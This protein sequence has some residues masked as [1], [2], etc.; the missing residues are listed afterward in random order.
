MNKFKLLFLASVAACL[1]SA[2]DAQTS[3]T[4]SLVRF[5]LVYG[6]TFFGDIDVELFDD[7]PLTVSNFLANVGS[8]IYDN[9]ILHDLRPGYTLQGGVG[10]VGNPYSG[11]PFEFI[12]RV[13]TNAPTPNEFGVGA[14][15][16]NV[17]GTLAM[18]KNPGDT[19][20]ASASWFFNLGNNGDGFGVTNLDA[21]LGGYT[22][23]G[24]VVKGSNVLA[25]FNT[26]T[27]NN[28]IQ[29]MTNDFHVGLCPPLY[30]LPDG[31]NIGF[32]A[33]PVGFFGQ[34]CIRYSDLFNVQIFKLNGSTDVTPPKVAIT[35][36]PSN[37]G[38]SGT[39][40][41]VVGT[42]TDNVGVESVRVYLN[43]NAPVDASGTEVWTALMSNV[44]PGTNVVVAEAVDAAGNRSQATVTFF[45]SIRVPFTL[46]TVGSGTVTGPANGD[47]LELGRAYTLVAKPAAGFLFAGYT[48]SVSQ[49][50]ATL[51]FIMESNFTVTAVFVANPFPAAKG[52]YNGLFYNTNVVEQ[53]SSGFLT[54]TLGD[55]GSYSARLYMNG[56]NYR[57]SGS[58][59][60]TGGGTN[61]ISRTGTNELLIRMALD[62]VGGGDHLSGSVTNDQILSIDTNASWSA[63]LMADRSVFN[64]K[65]NP[66]ALAGSYTLGIPVDTNSA[67]GP[68]GSGFATMAVTTA[69]SVSFAGTLA[70][71]TKAVQKVT[72]SKAGAVPIYVPLYKGA[73]ALVSW[74]MFDTNQPTTDVSGALNWFKQTQPTAKFYPGGLTNDVV[75]EGSRYI[76]PVSGTRAINLTNGVVAFTNGNL[77]ANFANNVTLGT[78]NRIQ[79]N[80]ANALTMSIQASKGSFTGSVTPPGGGSARP[81]KG[82]LIQK[83]TRGVGFLTGT[84]ETSD[85]SFH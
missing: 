43:T 53:R 19:N 55:L 24:R 79:N 34:D 31:I 51:P 72:V 45:R 38:V 21:S 74:L 66:A 30:L 17:F 16:S 83:Q 37:P 67:D 12:T 20:S 50:S 2:A 77:S 29:N 11:E 65:T 3:S 14:P 52:I 60:T 27:D 46:Q 81:Y 35:F 68:D 57:F 62:L 8:G 32:D 40:I 64:A 9:S 42:A 59:T 22:A 56:K 28:G 61:L 54:L 58:F 23:F 18:A 15:H 33:L 26:F 5:R 70:D 82:V 73:G 76:A 7:K 84:N 49:A 6:S 80:S 1:T 63:E 47:L 36:P 85:V 78:D 39:I 10:T 71:G 75:A 4:N 13:P 44:P 48:G 25:F 69:G 41:P